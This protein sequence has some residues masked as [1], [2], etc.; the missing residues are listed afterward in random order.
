MKSPPPTPPNRMPEIPVVRS[1]L[2]QTAP[3]RSTPA[4]CSAFAVAFVAFA[5]L[6]ASAAAFSAASVARAS[7][8]ADLR[9][10]R[11][12]VERVLVESGEVEAVRS[13]DLVAPGDWRSE[14]QIVFLAPEGMH[15]ETGDTLVRFDTREIL[16]QIRQAE[17]EVERKQA[18]IAAKQASQDQSMAGLR[19]A[20]R[21]AEFAAEQAELQLARMEFSAETERQ[22]ARLSFETAKLREA[23]AR[24]KLTAQATLDSLE[25]VQLRTG[26]VQARADLEREREQLDRMVLVAPSDGLVIHGES[27]DDDR[28]VR[29]GD[30]VSAGT[31]VVRLPDLSAIRVELGVHELDRVHLREG[32]AVRMFFDAYPDLHLNGTVQRIAQLAGPARRRSRIQRFDVMVSL[33]GSDP[34]LRPGMSARAEI[35][36]DRRED[37]LRVPRKALARNSEGPVVVLEDGTVRAVDVGL[38][39]PLWVELRDGPAE[40]TA[41]GRPA[42][43]DSFRL[44]SATGE[45]TS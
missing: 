28:K 4:A 23:E 3:V 20:L 18:E 22:S 39:T 19:N 34:R 25:L 14:P 12:A 37:V 40:G 30:D 5:V 26:L 45:P 21:N 36:V 15:A 17:T 8:R 16:T 10:T 29:A 31:V 44:E 7:E 41:L 2:Q 1:P 43:L 27:G 35:V 11:G 33:D 32:L 9:V 42:G 38:V 24:T 6:G 13:E